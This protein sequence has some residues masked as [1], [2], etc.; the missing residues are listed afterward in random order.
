M[1][2]GN[3]R[4]LGIALTIG[5]IGAALTFL[6]AVLDESRHFDNPMPLVVMVAGSLMFLGLM[7]SPIG[8]AIARML[9]DDSQPDEQL[10]MRVEDLEARVAE[11][12]MEQSRVMELEGRIDFAERMIAGGQSRG[13][14]DGTT[15]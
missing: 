2:A 3:S 10:A 12:S 7:R 15:H 4:G 8:K 14:T 11:L 1:S 13:G 9:E 5:L 6:V